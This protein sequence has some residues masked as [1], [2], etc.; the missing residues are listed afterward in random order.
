MANVDNTPPAIL[1]LSNLEVGFDAK[2][3][4][5]RS[6]DLRV[7]EGE[8]V[9]ISGLSGSGKTTLLRVIAGLQR[10]L[11]GHVQILNCQGNVPPPRGSVGYIPQRLGLVNHSTALANVLVGGLPQTPWW[12]AVLGLASKLLKEQA[13]QAL[14]DVGLAEHAHRPVK[15]MS[16]GQQ[17]RIA[18]ARALVQQPRLLLGDEFLGELDNET[19]RD[20]ADHVQTLL[21]RTGCA[22][23]L[24]DHDRSRLS[25]LADRVYLIEN[26]EL[27]PTYRTPIGEAQ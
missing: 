22:M 13:M 15:R 7:N 11:S 12:R 26:G 6:V 9:G 8:V 10:P 4:L 25:R 17:R 21:D 24:V 3:P 14:E 20:V 18:V 5:L 23:L 19:A 1:E 16:G 27:Q 2:N